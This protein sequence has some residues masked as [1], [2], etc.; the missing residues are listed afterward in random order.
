MKR[1][2]FYASILATTLA[3]SACSDDYTDW[4]TPQAWE[5]EATQDSIKDGIIT[6]ASETIDLDASENVEIARFMG[7]ANMPE[8]AKIRFTKVVLNDKTELNFTTNDT[9]VS[10]ESSE[11][12]SAIETFHNSLEQT[13]RTEIFTIYASI[14]NADGAS[15]P[16]AFKSNQ[17]SLNV[18]TQDRNLPAISQEDE[19]Y[20]VGGYNSWNLESPTKMDNNGDGTYSCIIELAEGSEWFCFAPKSAV[21]EKNWD[22]LFRAQKNGDTSTSGFFNFDSKQGYSFCAEIAKAGKYKF[23]INPKGWS[24]SYAPY[25]ESAYYAGDAN[26]WSFSPLAKV[27][28]NF[29]GYYYIYQPDNANTWGFKITAAANWDVQYGAGTEAGNIALGGDNIQ[30]TEPSAFYKL[31]VNT[32][33]LTYS[34]SPIN[35]MS[36]IGSAVNGDSSWGTDYDLTFNT[37]TMTWE[38]TY[39]MTDGEFKIRANHDWTL[40]WGV[41]LDAMTSQN[42]KNISI[43]AGTYKFEFKPNC[44]GQGV[45]KITAQ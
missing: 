32:E 12:Q 35:Q 42:G 43:S 34:V 36:L 17:V 19:F 21:E 18:R 33:T 20:Y 6:A 14:V 7:A 2:Y 41:E 10:V 1:I 37:E 45:L 30:I 15:T 39:E 9:I 13:T 29:E 5:Q 11:L 25:V 38:G 27:G 8:G 16:L 40:S 28:D 31:T 44:D 3:F 24:Y 26:G 4:A 23:T 22:G